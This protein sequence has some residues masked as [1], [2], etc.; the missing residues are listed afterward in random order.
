MK[1][2]LLTTALGVAVLFTTP[3]LAGS[4]GATPSAENLNGALLASGCV[5][6]HGQGGDS[7]GH[8]PSIDGLNKFQMVNAL[9]EFKSGARKGTIMPRIAPGYTDAQ[10]EAIASEIAGN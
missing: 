9:M 6:C 2:A 7:Q 4:G 5:V 3:A 8:I 1:K 10:I